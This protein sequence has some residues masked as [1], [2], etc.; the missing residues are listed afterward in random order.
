MEWFLAVCRLLSL[1]PYLWDVKRL[2][3]YQS[4]SSAVYKVV[5]CYF[6]RFD[7]Y[8]TP[9]TTLLVWWR[10]T[11][12]LFWLCLYKAVPEPWRSVY[13]RLLLSYPLTLPE[14][15]FHGYPLTQFYGCLWWLHRCPSTNPRI[16]FDDSAYTLWQFRRWAVDYPSNERSDFVKL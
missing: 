6:L 15:Q 5:A 11:A 4:N 12:I 9:L 1:C 10:Q 7:S 16:P 2:C 8:R 13:V 3:P 14:Q